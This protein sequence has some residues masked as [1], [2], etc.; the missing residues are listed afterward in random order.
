MNRVARAVSLVRAVLQL[1][2]CNVAR[3]AL[4]RARLAL[5]WRPKPPTAHYPATAVFGGDAL[6]EYPASTEQLLFGWC[7]YRIN[8]VPDWH[9]DPFDPSS[10]LDTSRDW[11]ASLIALQGRDPKAYWEL[12]R[13]YWVPQFAL[14]ARNGDAVAGA[15]LDGWLADWINR[16]PPYF[17]INWACGQEAAIRLMNLAL[18]ALILDTWRSPSSALKW[19]IEVHASRIS[20]TLSYAL[21]QDNNHGSA[22]ACALYLAGTWGDRW[23]M[24][25]A[26]RVARRG[27]RW[28]EDRALRLIQ[29][30]GSPSQ[31]SV[32]YHRAN[33]ETLALAALWA[34]RTGA[35]KLSSATHVRAARGARWLYQLI[36]PSTGDVPNLGAN[37]GSHLFSVPAAPYRDFRPTVALAAWLFERARPWAKPIDARFSA[38]G[39]DPGDARVWPAAS[40]SSSDIGGYHI[41]RTNRSMAVLRYPKFRFRPS[42][43]D[44]LHLDLWHAE[45][46][47]LRDAGTFSYCAETAEWFGSTAAHNTVEFDGRDQMP[48][49]GRFLFG[50]WLTAE[51]VELVETRGGNVTAAAAYTDRL[52][53][54]HHRRIALDAQKLTCTDTLSGI[55]RRACLRWRL[56]PGDWQLDGYMLHGNGVRIH[57]SAEMQPLTIMLD[58]TRESRYYRQCAEVPLVSVV[59]DRPTTVVTEVLFQ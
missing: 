14:A 21:A 48:R 42:Q 39:I 45:R 51:G 10:R 12:S 30:D 31:Y 56:E 58:M 37:D 24:G 38:L 29:S 9:A 3:V 25:S 36:D 2:G 18:A 33:I 27:K 7:P 57:I 32:T 19:L 11:H 8:D 22:E 15:R 35:P 54:C 40:S 46:N 16:N 50:D 49:L 1:G 43:A 4:Y 52:G 34:E 44:A 6:T 28:L 59:L 13:F 41:L 23:G 55:F 26:Q 20:P 5:G 53:A 47:L 17:G